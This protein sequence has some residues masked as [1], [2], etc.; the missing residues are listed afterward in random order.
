MKTRRT[1][2]G[3]VTITLSQGEANQVLRALHAREKELATQDHW[4]LLRIVGHVKRRLER[5]REEAARGP[6]Q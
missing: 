1:L 2:E 5:L 3:E 6:K 4:N